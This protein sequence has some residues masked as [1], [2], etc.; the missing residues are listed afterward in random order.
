MASVQSAPNLPQ[1]GAV[2]PAN[3]NTTQ[4]E[5]IWLVSAPE[6]PPGQTA[7]RAL[8]PTRLFSDRC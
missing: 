3:L 2:L 7:Y 5:Q 1:G 8:H 4:I 6:S